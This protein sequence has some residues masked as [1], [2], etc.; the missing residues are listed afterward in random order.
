MSTKENAIRIR[1]EL[2]AKLTRVLKAR[3]KRHSISTRVMVLRILADEL[4]NP[5]CRVCGCTD[6]DGCGGG[7][8]WVESDLC[9]ACVGRI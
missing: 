6:L 8:S 4:K 7:C 5:T 3:A 1:V 9:S 2:S